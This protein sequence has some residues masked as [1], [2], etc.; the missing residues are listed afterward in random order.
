[1]K[2]IHLVVHM[3]DSRKV[4]GALSAAGFNNTYSYTTGGFAAKENVTIVSVVADDK[5]E[6]FLKTVKQNIKPHR[7]LPTK[8]MDKGR[9]TTG[10]VAFVVPVERFE[11]LNSD[12][13]APG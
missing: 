4:I 6:R 9:I 5:I 3:D 7:E 1:M 13:A 10:A 11:R 2:L 12:Q 8:E